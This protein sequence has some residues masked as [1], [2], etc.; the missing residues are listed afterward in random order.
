MSNSIIECPLAPDA[1]NAKGSPG[2]IKYVVETTEGKREAGMG[3]DKMERRL[4]GPAKD[5][6]KVILE[7]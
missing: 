4:I 2:G 6:A 1:T 3:V 5:A 7:A